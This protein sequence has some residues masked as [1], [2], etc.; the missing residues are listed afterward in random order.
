MHAIA[1]ETSGA[2]VPVLPQV[3]AFPLKL[4]PQL[5]PLPRL[6]RPAGRR[7]PQLRG[8]LQL[9]SKADI[10]PA[11][12]DGSRWQVK[13]YNSG[14]AYLTA[15]VEAASTLT[16]EPAKAMGPWLGEA[17]A[18]LDAA[19]AEPASC[20]WFFTSSE[21]VGHLRELGIGVRPVG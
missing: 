18:L 12:L 2:T 17:R 7:R 3:V 11:A 13:H 6:Q 10:V 20:C 14:A 16:G 8:Q 9:I 1:P 4:E 19:I 5:Q 21:A 15:A